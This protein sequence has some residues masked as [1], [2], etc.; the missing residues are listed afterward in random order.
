MLD[1]NQ[2]QKSVKQPAVRAFRFI[3]G[4]GLA[5]WRLLDPCPYC[6]RLH[7]HNAAPLDEPNAVMTR[8]S[9]C[10]AYGDLRGGEYQLIPVSSPAEE[11][12]E[13]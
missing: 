8:Q 10:Y 2:P 13:I 6:A 12:V 1:L 4:R 9:H 7:T 5:R 11:S 3:D